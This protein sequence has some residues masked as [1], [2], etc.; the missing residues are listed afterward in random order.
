MAKQITEHK[1]RSLT[2]KERRYRITESNLQVEINPSGR[3]VFYCEGRANGK[4]FRKHLGDYPALSV[5]DAREAVRR[6]LTERDEGTRI[7]D[8]PS[9][10]EAFVEGQFRDWCESNRKQGTETMNRIRFTHVPMFGSKKLRAITQQ[11]VE[12]HKVRLLKSKAN[13]TVKRDLGDLRRIFS[14]AVEWGLLRSSPAANVADPKVEHAEK[15]YLTDA[16]MGR[17]HAALDEWQV[18]A[19][20][21]W[22]AKFLPEGTR[23]GRYKHHPDLPGFVRLLVNTGLRR[24]EAL[25][26]EWR[27]VTLDN[28][29]ASL[30]VRPEIAKSGR[31]R[32]IPINRKLAGQLL[33]AMGLS[34]DEA[35]EVHRK[36]LK[37]RG[38]DRIFTLQHPA[39]AWQ[40]LRKSADLDHVTLHH[41]RHNFASQLV[42]KG[43]PLH[44]VSKLLGHTDLSTTQIYLSVRTDDEIEA[45]NLL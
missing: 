5:K 24:T 1:I 22:R 31:R 44:V 14:K 30:T 4:R 42:L 27:D 23:E 15:L 13:S 34:P 33:P 9:T 28:G 3:R 39:K 38:R 21:E 18:K 2:G 40:R 26:L 29:T 37:S 7:I 36:A 8:D 17:L 32:V 20:A 45:V 43:V 41:L 16:E 6:I 19:D 35:E 10:F 11:D 25:S 12:R